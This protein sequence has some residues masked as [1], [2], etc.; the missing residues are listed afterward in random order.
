MTTGTTEAAAVAPAARKPFP[1]WAKAFYERSN[2]L[3]FDLGGGRRTLALDQAINIQKVITVFFI[4]G[5]MHWYGNFSVGAWVYLG[6]HGVYG[7]TW[8]DRP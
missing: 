4:Y 1:A 7:Y 2:H 5:L 3:L 8:L 6:L